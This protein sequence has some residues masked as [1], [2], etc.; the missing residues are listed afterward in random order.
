[1]AENTAKNLVGLFFGSTL[2]V[3]YYNLEITVIV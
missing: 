3:C 2:Y 1:V